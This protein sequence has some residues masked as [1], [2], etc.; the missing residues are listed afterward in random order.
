MGCPPPLNSDLR[1]TFTFDKCD[2]KV[3]LRKLRQ[4]GICRKIG[5]WI[6][7][8]LGQRQ[9]VVVEDGTRVDPVLVKSGVPHGSV[10][11]SLLFLILISDINKDVKHSSLSLFEDNTRV[12][13]HMSSEQDSKSLQQD[14]EAVYNWAKENNMNF[15]SDKFECISFGGGKIQQNYLTKRGANSLQGLPLRSGCNHVK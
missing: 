6:A 10:I 8:F 9:Q 12:W 5:V 7:N 4:H 15:N 3:I 14:L 13:K 11:G 1:P 2:H